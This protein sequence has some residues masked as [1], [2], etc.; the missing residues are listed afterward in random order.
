[1]SK[2]INIELIGDLE[3][4]A[5][6]ASAGE[7]AVPALKQAL[8]E[9]AQLAFRESQRVVPVDTG[10]LRRSGQIESAREVPTG[11][12]IVLGYGGAAKAYALRQHEDLSYSHKEGQQAKYLEDPVRGRIPKLMQN[13]RRRMER[14]LSK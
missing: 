8:T 5:I 10:T 14:I 11:V 4:K 7:K 12:E 2:T 1:M 9:E 3:L 6:L 13:I